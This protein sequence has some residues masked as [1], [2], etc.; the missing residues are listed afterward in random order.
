M[1]EKLQ[2]VEIITPERRVYSA[3]VRFVVLPGTEG[4]LGIL[5]DHAPL[6]TALKIDVVRIT[7]EGKVQKIAVH[8][9]FAEVRNNRVIILANAAERAEEIDRAR[10]EAAKQRAETRLAARTPDIDVVRAEL[11]LK[12]ALARLKALEN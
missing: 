2:R 4:E 8:G 12:R 3:D 9:G 5:P 1:A 7:H 6:V 10:A 11:A